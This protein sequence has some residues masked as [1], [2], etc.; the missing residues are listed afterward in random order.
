LLPSPALGKNPH[1]FFP[2]FLF[3]FSP[4]LSVFAP[5]PLSTFCRASIPSIAVFNPPPP[6]R[7]FGDLPPSLHLSPPFPSSFLSVFFCLPRFLQC[8]HFKT[9]KYHSWTAI[10]SF[11]R[12]IHL[13]PVVI[14]PLPINISNVLQGKLLFSVRPPVK[15]FS[16]SRPCNSF[17]L[18]R[19]FTMDLFFY[20]FAFL[21]RVPPPN[22]FTLPTVEEKL[23]PP[24][25]PPMPLIRPARRPPP[26]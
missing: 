18:T 19:M 6:K 17:P 8:L 10:P 12:A 26:L 24:A 20:L 16:A 3:P 9:I 11:G 22:L 13:P 1:M 2:P 15:T 23:S 14:V 21:P 4:T 5:A 25:C 7:L